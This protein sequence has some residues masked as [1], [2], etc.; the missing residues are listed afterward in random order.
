VRTK[1]ATASAAEIDQIVEVMNRLT[2][3][4]QKTERARGKSFVS[5]TTLMP[6]EY[7]R[8]RTVVFRVVLA[9]PLTNHQ[10]LADVLE[11]QK[12]IAA[13]ADCAELMAELRALCEPPALKVKAG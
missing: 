5:R 8:R 1:L 6:E 11:E 12:Q 3:K 10:I 13:S 7:D 9:N 2:K 4:I